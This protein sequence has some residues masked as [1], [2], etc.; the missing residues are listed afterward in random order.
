MKVKIAPNTIMRNFLRANLVDINASRVGQWI[1]DDPPR[2]EDLGNNSFPR[3][4]VLAIGESSEHLGI[5]DDGQYETVTLQID[6]WTKKDQIYTRTITD[7][8]LGTM[9]ASVNSNRFTADFVPTTVTNVEHAGT[10]YSTVTFVDNDVD[11]TTPASLGS[12]T[13]EVSKATGNFNF[14]AADVSGD[15]GEAITT[16]YDKAMEGEEV[17]KYLSREVVKEVRT[18]WRTDA[19]FEG[20]FYPVKVSGPVN[21]PLDNDLGIFRYNVDYRVNAFNLGEGI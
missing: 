14:S 21:L 2:L 1:F 3:I 17:V 10:P 5:F 20:L 15:D 18:G 16:T 19:T 11:F 4:S 13:V 12:G 6:C 8:A 7:E 9:N